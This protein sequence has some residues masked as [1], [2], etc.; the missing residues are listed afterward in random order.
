MIADHSEGEE[1]P[2]IDAMTTPKKTR[3]NRN[4]PASGVGA[5]LKQLR[6]QRGLSMVQLAREV[7]VTNGM[8][9]QI[10]N[11]LA[12]PSL[13]TLRKLAQVLGVPVFYFFIAHENDPEVRSSDNRYLL[14]SQGNGVRYEFISD[15]NEPSL[16]FTM[17]EAK[18]GSSSGQKQDV[19]PGTECA[20][21]LK[22]RMVLE[23]EDQFYELKAN[24]SITFDSLRP[25][26]WL[27]QGKTLLKFVSVTSC[28]VRGS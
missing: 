20:L 27:N 5:R 19:H 3:A 16:E 8:I 2:R 17:I 12:D 13:T 22:G 10:E 1:T 15:P 28:S 25:H 11:H 7:G 26:R 14:N 21:V 9:S 23:I 4:R 18:P 6:Q 24:D